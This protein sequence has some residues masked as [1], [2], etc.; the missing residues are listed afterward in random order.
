MVF[1]FA[2]HKR[3]ATLSKMASSLTCAVC[4][5]PPTN[6]KNRHC[7]AYGAIVCLSCKAFFKR[8][9]DGYIVD[10][11]LKHH[12]KNNSPGNCD[13]HFEAKVKDKCKHCRYLKCLAAG[14]DPDKITTGKDRKKY[15][16]INLHC[17]KR[18]NKSL[19]HNIDL[20]ER[21]DLLI[22]TYQSTMNELKVE[23]SLM[24]FLFHGHC[25]QVA[26]TQRHTE[27]FLQAME[28]HSLSII[29]MTS[30]LE[31]FQLICQEDRNMLCQMNQYLF[32]HYIMS[33]YFKGGS[34]QMSW[35]LGTDA[36]DIFGK[37]IVKAVI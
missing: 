34:T 13:V 9:H 12:C 26:W 5:G 4:L 37:I 25:H 24:D 30:S 10:G 35:L 14:M 16:R 21:M 22:G 33:R 8:C 18:S 7:L 23:K 28:I 15:T 29:K 20:N 11:V 2:V 27:A 19:I 1:I 32:Y 17:F 6:G 3:H 31:F 36:G